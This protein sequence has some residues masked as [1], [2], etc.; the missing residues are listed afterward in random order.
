VDFDPGGGTFFLTSVEGDDDFDDGND[1]G[2]DFS[3]DIYVSRLSTTASSWA[4]RGSD[5][6]A[7]TLRVDW[8]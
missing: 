7:M 1:S 6:P 4:R 3:Y 5:Q 2:R 8:R